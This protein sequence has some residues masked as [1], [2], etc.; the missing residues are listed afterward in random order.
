MSEIELE[1]RSVGKNLL[2]YP[3]TIQNAGRLIK[4]SRSLQSQIDFEK[5]EIVGINS[6][7]A[8]GSERLDS[9]LAIERVRGAELNDFLGGLR[10]MTFWV[11]R[12][13]R[14]YRKQ[15]IDAVA[16]QNVYILPLA[17]RL[18]KKAGAIF[19]YNA[20]ELETETIGASGI[21]K[22]FVKFIERRYIRRA[23][24]VSVV[25][26][27]IADWY[28]NEYPGLRRPV[29]LTNTPI[30]D[31]SSVDLRSKFSV[32]ADALLYIHVG[33]ITDGRNVPLLL[34]EFA[35]HP[36]AHVV[37]LGDGRMRSAVVQAGL[38]CPNIHWHPPVAPDRV[39][40]Y[41]R[42]A[43]VGLCLI[44][45]VSLSDE[46]ST[47]NKLMESLVAGLP[48]LCSDLVE[49]KRLI[50]QEASNT[51][52]LVEPETQLAGALERITFENVN[53]FKMN[54]S[55]VPSWEEQASELI[56]IYR[57]ELENM[58]RVQSKI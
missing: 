25:N 10:V 35:A 52:I 36:K 7:V 28:E 15:N 22:K 5:T 16:A 42:G 40:S 32:P 53:E 3:S 43:D 6:G 31:G 23:D 18:S 19:A 30:D 17:Y 24:V 20:H 34:K 46:L 29:V 50:G 48:T 49:A 12:V 26:D 9:N 8:S 13:Y 47:P 56:E 38:T 55:G 37:F 57:S 2:I 41:V 58:H 1:P 21:K 51:W 44:E 39:V 4:I 11:W 27:S 54:W 14:K 33:F 45:Y